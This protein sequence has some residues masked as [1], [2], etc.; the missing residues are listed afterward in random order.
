[1]SSLINKVVSAPKQRKHYCA[2]NCVVMCFF[3]FFLLWNPFI[4]KGSS[5]LTEHVWESNA[6]AFSLKV[7]TACTK[8]CCWSESD[9]CESE[10]SG[11]DG[12][13][14]HKRSSR[15]CVFSSIRN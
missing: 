3:F 5:N 4:F 15:R 14:L 12:S 2:G 7:Y 8:G 13:L 10:R 6:V 1:M 11:N 9:T